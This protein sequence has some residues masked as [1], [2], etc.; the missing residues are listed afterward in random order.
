MA[1]NVASDDLALGEELGI[2]K[3]LVAVERSAV[4]IERDGRDHLAR[5]HVE[6]GARASAV[7]HELD[8]R[9]GEVSAGERLRE[10]LPDEERRDAV[11]GAH[12]R[13]HRRAHLGPAIVV[14]HHVD[15][16]ERK[17]EDSREVRRSGEVWRGRRRARSRRR[18]EDGDVLVGDRA[19]SWGRGGRGRGLRVGHRQA[20]QQQG[21]GEHEL[22]EPHPSHPAGIIVEKRRVAWA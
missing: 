5:H 17:V 15:R 10:R 6:R 16:D 7:L 9:I 1:R 14:D 11:A 3:Q 8:V 18:R 13:D 12:L 4:E 19:K 21:K 2:A 20:P 22:R